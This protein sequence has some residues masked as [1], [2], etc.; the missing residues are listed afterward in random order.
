MSFIIAT[1]VIVGRIY[2]RECNCGT[3]FFLF[4]LRSFAVG[5]AS[6]LN[7]TSLQTNNEVLME[8]SSDKRTWYKLKWHLCHKSIRILTNVDKIQDVKYTLKP[9]VYA[10]NVPT[11]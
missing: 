4:S 7:A 1:D 3:W 11:K 2:A 10:A 8:L 6:Y 5:V 9:Y